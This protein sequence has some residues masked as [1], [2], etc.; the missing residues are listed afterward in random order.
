MGPIWTKAFFS[1]P[2]ISSPSRPLRGS[3]FCDLTKSKIKSLIGRHF[4]PPK[5]CKCPIPLPA[6]HISWTDVVSLSELPFDTFMV[7]QWLINDHDEVLSM[8][9]EKAE[10]FPHHPLI[11]LDHNYVIQCIY[12]S[13]NCNYF[14]YNKQISY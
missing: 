10:I 13:G 14:V 2:A 7:K 1:K 12:K 9:E 5:E 3:P 11:E 8:M 4:V 6:T